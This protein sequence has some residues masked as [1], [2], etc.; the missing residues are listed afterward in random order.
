M[1]QRGRQGGGVCPPQILADQ[2]VLPYYTPPQIFR[3]WHT[4]VISTANE[5]T[6]VYRHHWHKYNLSANFKNVWST[7]RYFLTVLRL[8]DVFS[9]NWQLVN[10]SSGWHTRAIMVIARLFKLRSK[11][12]FPQTSPFLQD[13]GFPNSFSLQKWCSIIG[14]SFVII[15]RLTPKSSIDVSHSWQIRAVP[16]LSIVIA[17]KRT[18]EIYP[19]F[20][21]AKIKFE[22]LFIMNK[23]IW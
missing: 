5:Y 7:W 16:M 20:V 18:S 3:L 9:R 4:P 13:F 15:E 19:F 22:I 8:V 10:S 1:C 6:F 17:N 14:K 21:I 23:V 2:K 11:K 12:C